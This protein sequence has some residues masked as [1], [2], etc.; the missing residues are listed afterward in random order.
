MGLIESSVR[1]HGS[2]PWSDLGWG[3][4][5]LLALLLGFI[6]RV[7]NFFRNLWRD[8]VYQ[9]G[10]KGIDGLAETVDPARVRTKTL[11]KISKQNTEA[12]TIIQDTMVTKENHAELI[13]RVERLDKG[14]IEILKRLTKNGGDTDDAGDVLWRIAEALGVADPVAAKQRR[15]RTTDPRPGPH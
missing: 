12:I 10:T 5:A 4:G 2:F 6:K 14:Q 1:T 9:R 8:W 3:G 11:E 13:D 7:R 15:R